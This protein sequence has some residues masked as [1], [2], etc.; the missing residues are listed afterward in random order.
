MKEEIFEKEFFIPT[1]LVLGLQAEA[2]F[3]AFLSHSKNYKLL[4]ANLQIQGASET[5]GELDYIVRK[6]K[7]SQVIHIELAYKF[8]L[9]DKDATDSEEEKW[10]GPNRKDSLFEKLEKIKHKQFPILY[11]DQTIQTLRKLNIEIPS[12]QELCLKA[13]LF[14]PKEM[15]VAEFPMNYQECILGKWMKYEDFHKDDEMAVYAIPT[16]KEW[17]L[18]M[19]N[20][21]KWHSF[22]EVKILIQEQLHINK[23]PM[24][25]KKNQHTI[26]RFFVVWW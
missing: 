5:L 9:Y 17:L 11:A 22:S 19:E 6:I 10:I 25:Y 18:P 24:I 1:N 3:E 13:S 21:S 20:I 23:S 26:E 12:I 15:D 16:K 2:C 8:Y 7:T 14:I 4:S